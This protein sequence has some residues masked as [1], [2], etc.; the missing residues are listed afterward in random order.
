MYT[1]NMAQLTANASAHSSTAD[2]MF[3]HVDGSD[4]V[5]LLLW[6]AKYRRPDMDDQD[7]GKV[8]DSWLYD[9]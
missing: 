6:S 4:P 2:G 9:R 1:D 7:G 3:D 5:N 8:P